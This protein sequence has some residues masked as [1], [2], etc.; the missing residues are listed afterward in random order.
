[1]G[2]NGTP[3]LDYYGILQEV[4]EVQYVRGNHIVLFK[5]DWWD[6]HSQ[7]WETVTDCF[8]F[9]SIDSGKRLVNDP[10]VLASQARQVFYVEDVTKSNWKMVVKIKPRNFYDVPEKDDRE[11]SKRK[12]KKAYKTD[13]PRGLTRNLKAKMWPGE[14]LKVD[15]NINGQP[16]GDHKATLAN[17]HRALFKDPLNASLYEVEQFSQIP[18]ENKDKMW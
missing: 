14:N 4:I 10:Y 3:N 1:M 8:N 16:I 11:R 2:E 7:G 15:F 13:T 5:C 12:T 18:Q 6:V 17:Y 9:I